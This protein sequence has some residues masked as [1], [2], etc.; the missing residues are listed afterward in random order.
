MVYFKFKDVLDK[1]KTYNE[2]AIL[3]ENIIQKR[4]LA[5]VKSHLYKQLLISL[6]LNPSH[7]NVRLQ[8][9][10]QLDFASILFDVTLMSYN[11]MP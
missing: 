6:K 11:I 1:A 7:Q 3:K 9:R 10:E 8:I 4:Q 2:A 5:N